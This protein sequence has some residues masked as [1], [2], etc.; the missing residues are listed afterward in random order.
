M[1]DNSRSELESSIDRLYQLP[2]DRFTPERNALAAELRKSGRRVEADQVKAL[3]KPS[4]TAWAVNQAWWTARPAFEA[5][6]DAGMRLRIE[7]EALARGRTVDLR[8]AADARQGAVDAVISVAVDVLGGDAAVSPQARHRIA[9]TCEALASSGVPADATVGRLTADLQSTG[10]DVLSALAAGVPGKGLAPAGPATPVGRPH[11]VARSEGPAS[12]EDQ[13][14][15]VA[16]ARVAEAKADLASKQA[17]LR[18][19]EVD[20]TRASA[21]EARA[22]RL[23]E[24]AAERMRSLEQELDATREDERTTRRALAEATKAASAADFVRA[25]SA[26]A[27]DAA[28]RRLEE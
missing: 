21:D 17:A 13:A 12:R 25:Q 19:A 16:A 14:A 8:R 11:V 9:G 26:R 18:E 7:H 28:K 4:Q 15:R 20:A 5:M 23:H 10:L 6:L 3:A 1:T 2:L 22:R 24:K 27:V